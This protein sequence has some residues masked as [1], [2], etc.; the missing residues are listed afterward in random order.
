MKTHKDRLLESLY[1]VKKIER[2]IRDGVVDL[3]VSPAMRKIADI[4][5]FLDGLDQICMQALE[6]VKRVANLQKPFSNFDDVN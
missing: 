6:D 5:I 1:V 3:M 4:S 2:P